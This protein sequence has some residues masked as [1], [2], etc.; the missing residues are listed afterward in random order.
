M[1]LDADTLSRPTGIDTMIYSTQDQL[2][3][4]YATNTVKDTN[5]PF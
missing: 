2:T 5:V 3:N 1:S 4:Y